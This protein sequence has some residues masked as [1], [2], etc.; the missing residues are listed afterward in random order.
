MP[1]SSSWI[2]S[3]RGPAEEDEPLAV[4]FVVVAAF[5]IQLGPIVVL[6][7]MHEVHR[8]LVARQRAAQERAGHHLAADGH[9]EADAGRFD[10]PAAV[11]RLPKRGQDDDRLVAQLGQFERQA[12]AHVA[13]PA[14][15]AERHRLG[16]GEEDFHGVGLNSPAILAG[17]TIGE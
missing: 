11:E 2:A 8:H 5:A 14:R 17:P 3:K 4:V 9:F 12:A 16:R 7:L 1:R 15:L 10:R 13:Q 6:R